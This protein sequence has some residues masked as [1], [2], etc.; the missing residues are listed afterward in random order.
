MSS[1]VSLAVRLTMPCRRMK[2][3]L[4]SP[5]YR[6]LSL[7]LPCCVLN[8]LSLPLTCDEY[9]NGRFGPSCSKILIKGPLPSDL[10]AALKETPPP[11]PCHARP[12]RN[13]LPISYFI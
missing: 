2:T 3:L 13:Q 7:S 11:V 5:K 9:G 10:S 1:S 8:S 4:A 6:I 12:Q